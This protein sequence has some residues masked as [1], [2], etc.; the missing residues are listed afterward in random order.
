[1]KKITPWI[2]AIVASLMLIGCG[3]DTYQVAPNGLYYKASNKNCPNVSYNEDKS[4]TCYDTDKRTI[5]RTIYPVSEDEVRRYRA[6]R[7]AKREADRKFREGQRA[8]RQRSFNPMGP[9]I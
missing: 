3:E 4:I 7:D 1:M 9:R 6:E 2:M 8:L 5:L